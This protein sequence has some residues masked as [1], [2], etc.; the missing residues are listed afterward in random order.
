MNQLKIC[1]CVWL[2]AMTA[3]CQTPQLAS[4]QVWVNPT[5]LQFETTNTE[6]QAVLE[7]IPILFDTITNANGD[8]M[9]LGVE[10]N[11]LVFTVN[12][13]LAEMSDIT[14]AINTNWITIE[15]ITNEWP[16]LDTNSLDDVTG[17]VY[18]VTNAWGA[19]VTNQQIDISFKSNAWASSSMSTTMVWGMYKTNLMGSTSG[20]SEWN[21]GWYEWTNYTGYCDVEARTQGCDLAN[22]R[23]T[24]PTTGWYSVCASMGVNFVNIDYAT[25][26]GLIVRNGGTPTLVN[27]LKPDASGDWARFFEVDHA[28][29]IDTAFT[30]GFTGS[31]LMHLTNGA[32]VSVYLGHTSGWNDLSAYYCTLRMNYEGE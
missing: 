23:I 10:S 9:T 1:F 11:V 15:G 12:T 13:N 26:Y 25:I 19:V 6:L 20:A 14:D 27:D 22:G 18:S 21:A 2:L 16:Y 4:W 17:V 7:D 31:T 24:A 32:Y 28:P 5:N 30:W 8:V 29:G 3:M